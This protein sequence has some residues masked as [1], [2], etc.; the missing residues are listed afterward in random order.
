MDT[1]VVK[2]PFVALRNIGRPPEARSFQFN[3]LIMGIVNDSD[4]GKWPRY[5]H[6]ELLHLTSLL[7]HPL[8]E[9]MPLDSRL[10]KKLFFTLKSA[11]GTVSLFFPDKI[12]SGNRQALA[13]DGDPW[14]KTELHYRETDDRQRYIRQSVSRVR[15]ALWRLGCVPRGIIQS[16]PGGGIHY[17]GTIPMGS[18]PKRCNSLGQS[19]LF[20]NLYIAD[21]A[22]FP[23]LPSKSITMSLAAH[24]TRV[25]TLAKL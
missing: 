21:G 17:A 10:S 4:N 20:S 24:A 9:W 1:S 22:A 19:N 13:D 5:L 2:L 11:L 6:G 25:A 16:P 7:Y 23:S 14:E 12:T 15:A 3:R 18:G 8:I